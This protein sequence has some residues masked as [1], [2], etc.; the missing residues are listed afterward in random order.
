MYAGVKRI[1]S[2]GCFG[3]SSVTGASFEL[4][5][6]SQHIKQEDYAWDVC[7]P[8]NQR[9]GLLNDLYLEGMSLPLLGAILLDKTLVIFR[10]LILFFS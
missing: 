8:L 1:G 6:F 9:L 2:M 3:Q 4:E 10:K 7:T 5:P